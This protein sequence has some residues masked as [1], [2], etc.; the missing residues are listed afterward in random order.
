MV[1]LEKQ[2]HLQNDMPPEGTNDNPWAVVAR[3]NR[4]ST[5]HATRCGDLSS[6][7]V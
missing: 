7:V 3:A 5:A 1:E 2:V 4:S 6:I